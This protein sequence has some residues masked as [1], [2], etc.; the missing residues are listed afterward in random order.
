MVDHDR[1]PTNDRA[2]GLALDNLL[3]Y[4]YRLRV[5]S[6][7]FAVAAHVLSLLA[8]SPNDEGFTSDFLAGSVNTHPAF[9]RRVV[10]K[11][12]IAGI[13]ETSHGRGGGYRLARRAHKIRLSD[14]YEAVEPEGPL[15]PSHAEPNQACPIGSGIREAFAVLMT[16][17]NE[18]M[19]LGLASET[20]SDLAERAQAMGRKKKRGPRG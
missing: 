8:I 19:Q 18:A 7:Q 5:S 17:A 16:R 14:V 3:L 6:G 1:V 9:V 12:V 13:V 10:G 2:A 11:L 15:S 4:E 20:V